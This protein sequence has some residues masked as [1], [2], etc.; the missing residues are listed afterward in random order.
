MLLSEII[1]DFTEKN[2]EAINTLCGKKMRDIF[3]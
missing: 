2:T 1:M 3:C